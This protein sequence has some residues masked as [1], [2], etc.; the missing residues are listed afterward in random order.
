M[1]RVLIFAGAPEAD[2]SSPD[3]LLSTPPAP[4]PTST[5]AAA[6]PAWRSLPF[7]RAPLVTG[8][9]QHHGLPSDF[10]PPAHFFS[11]S[12]DVDSQQS[13]AASQELL[14]Q[15]Y[16]HSL[17]LHHDLPSSQLPLPSQSHTG[18]P[19]PDTQSFETTAADSF[20]TTT[21]TT[22][23]DSSFQD[24]T[25]SIRPPLTTSHHLSDLED[26]PTGP[27]LLRLAPQ[28]VTVNLIAGVI[29]VSAPRSITTRWGT[30]LALVEVLV[31]D[32]TRAG[33]GVT[34]WVPAS[35]KSTPGATLPSQ[36][37]RQDVV[38]MQNVALHVFRG[39]VYGQSL[40]KGLT[41]TT[42]LYRRKMG[43]DDEGGYYRRRDLGSG[44]SGGS[45]VHPQL[46]K[47][48]R[49]W[50]WVLRFVGGE[51]RPAAEDGKGKGRK[52]GWDLPPDDTQ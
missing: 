42:V 20:M 37:R 16:D 34:F 19:P 14:S 52:R 31:G 5:P 6:A 29:S 51:Q 12:L 4:H 36:L 15:F 18:R 40:R 13:V 1:P 8:F 27:D 22:T 32:D 2:W 10:R 11:L 17:A 9:S 21:T 33:F 25:L 49:V 26:I 30:E 41:R 23:T 24:T 39:K 3:L 7:H 48:R 45:A 38:L 47:T 28:T 50:E 43:E 46:A 44:D 35:A